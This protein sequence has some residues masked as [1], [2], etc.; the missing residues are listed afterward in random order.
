MNN[1]DNILNGKEIAA[2]HFAK[3][4]KEIAAL[5]TQGTRLTLA[6]IQVGG[7]H[8][9]KLYAK[10]IENFIKKLGINHKPLVF[11]DTI[12]EYA[13]RLEINRLN[14]DPEVTGIL[15][16]APLPRHLHLE[17][18]L[19][20]LSILK[21]VEGRR[22]LKNGINQVMPPT[23]MA[24]V[25]LFEET[26]I[27]AGG[28]EAL[29]IGRSD[30]VGKPAALLMLDKNATVTI[31]HSQ[32]KDLEGHVKRSDIVIVS[33]GKANLVKGHWIKS[34]AVVIDVGENVVNGKIVGDVEF[35]KAKERAAFISPVPGG[36]GP[37]TNVMLVRN[38]ITLSGLQKT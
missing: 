32:T 16:F 24:A 14:F 6:T 36:V 5:K 22:L 29:I 20:A 28:K 25:A 1:A 26:G 38:L 27:E 34:G 9:S 2:K 18:L 30:V 12:Q 13:L 15:I 4:S 31:A 7:A 17:S 33:V 23:A 3:L 35:E 37:V 21:D 11:Q 19:S 10:T 8:E